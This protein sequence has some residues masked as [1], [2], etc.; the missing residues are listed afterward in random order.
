[1]M[2]LRPK[3]LLGTLKGRPSGPYNLYLALWSLSRR[4]TQTSLP[5]VPR[6]VLASVPRAHL[7]AY[8]PHKAPRR[9]PPEACWEMKSRASYGRT[10]CRE[11]GS[12]CS[13][14]PL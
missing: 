14:G 11:M 5:Q 6:R 8:I 2:R 9:P 4:Q 12:P 13:P 7:R 10:A 3:D 1:M